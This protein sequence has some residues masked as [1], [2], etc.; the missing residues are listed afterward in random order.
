MKFKIGLLT[1]VIFIACGC[2][3]EYNL[4]ISKDGFQEITSITT[5]ISDQEMFVGRYL[6]DILNV[7][8]EIP[9]SFRDAGDFFDINEVKIYET[10]RIENSNIAG[11]ELKNNFNIEEIYLSNVINRCYEGFSLSRNGH[12]YTIRTDRLARCFN[13]YSLLSTLTI[14]ITLADN[15]ELILSN[16]DRV[17]GNIY[18]WVV[19]R[20][21]F[22]NKPISITY[23]DQVDTRPPSDTTP[24]PIPPSEND[25]TNIIIIVAI[26]L[27]TFVILLGVFI[28]MKRKKL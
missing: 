28:R 17:S 9:I 7:N 3:A 2:R 4:T 19:N 25:Q 12:V 24:D 16:A 22:E 8:L 18:T 1:L 5:N 20:D 26:S 10:R 14:N 11:V 15:Y 13:A 21:N 23:T 6:T 27:V